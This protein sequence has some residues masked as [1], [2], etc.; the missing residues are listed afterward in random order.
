MHEVV[1]L[2]TELLPAPCRSASRG[3]LLAIP[4]GGLRVGSHSPI[5]LLTVGAWRRVTVA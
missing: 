3:R 4:T 1:S 2:T 5:S